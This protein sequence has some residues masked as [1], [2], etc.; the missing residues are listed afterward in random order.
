[1]GIF[2]PTTQ[3]NRIIFNEND[4]RH[5]PKALKSQGVDMQHARYFL[6]SFYPNDIDY[7]GVE[8]LSSF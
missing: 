7:S 3:E 5:L 4:I 2:S 8:A 1:M 6:E